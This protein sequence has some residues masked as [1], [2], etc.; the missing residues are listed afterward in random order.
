MTA[1]EVANLYP[2]AVGK[3]LFDSEASVPGVETFLRANYHLKV[4]N[5]QPG[6]VLRLQH[7][8]VVEE[9]S[10]RLEYYIGKL[11][12]PGEMKIEMFIQ[13]ETKEVEL[14]GAL[15]QRAGIEPS[16]WSK[17]NKCGS[18]LILNLD[19]RQIIEVF[20]KDSAVK[21]NREGNGN[22][23]VMST[24]FM[25]V[26]Y[27]RYAS[28]MNNMKCIVDIRKHNLRLGQAERMKA[29]D[30]PATLCVF[31]IYLNVTFVAFCDL[32]ECLGRS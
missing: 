5:F 10:D 3:L 14:D 31:P 1:L 16:D 30:G 11:K 27:W 8:G 26:Q 32:T 6:D 20:G 7:T 9:V 25:K 24:Y 28:A 13:E 23:Y 18:K 22:A 29:G 21:A 2:H 4:L 12:N 19:Q 17:A 15:R